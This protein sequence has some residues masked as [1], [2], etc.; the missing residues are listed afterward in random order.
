MEPIDSYRQKNVSGSRLFELYDDR[1]VV[2]GYQSFSSRF[3][4]T[5]P[6][7]ILEPTIIEFKIR[8][9]NDV[10]GFINFLVGGWGVLSFR[11]HPPIYANPGFWLCGF[12][13]GVGLYLMLTAI[14]DVEAA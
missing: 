14:H 13:A 10:A 5:V 6:L 12:Y 11:N 1:V 4:R 2:S 8:S 9:Y 7:V 3:K